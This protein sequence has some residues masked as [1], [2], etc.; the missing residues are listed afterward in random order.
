MIKV[1][2]ALSSEEH[3]SKELVRQAVA[4]EQAGFDF[5]GIS[6]HF[7]P[8]LDSQGQ[9]PFVWSVLG[10]IA[11]STERVQVGTMVTCPIMR[12][13]PAIVAHA[14][15]TVADMM[16]GR[17]FLGL[18]SGEN[19][20]EHITGEGWPRTRVRIEMLE[21]ATALIERMWT[22]ENVSYDGAYFT[23]ANARI[24]TLP[25]PLP[26]IY[27][28]ASGPIA[29]RLAGRI[30]DGLIST[31]PDRELVEAFRSN[32]NDGPRLGQLAICLAESEEEGVRLASKIWPNSVLSGSFK[33]ELPLPAHFE[34]ACSVVTPDQVAEAIVCSN[35]P[36]R[37][38]DAIKEY[39][40][41]GFTHVFVHQIG[42]DQQRFIDFYTREVMAAVG[43]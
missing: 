38:I 1:G 26:P 6:D 30:G 2:Y 24:Y 12:T 14:A 23:L 22:G 4:A 10:G 20:N 15:A 28:A 41:A 11:S 37:H 32:G 43:V 25:D 42:P 3:A 39:E 21:E 35:D 5:V 8:W 9:S 33:Q 19:L 16:P 36:Q 31:S 27:L 29:A 13:H 17:F 34:Q 18:G 40:E 7:H